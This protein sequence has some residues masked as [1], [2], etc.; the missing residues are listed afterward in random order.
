M[1]VWQMKRRHPG[2]NCLGENCYAFGFANNCVL[3][4]DVVI[5]G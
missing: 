2:H 5:H 4:G 3:F 1:G